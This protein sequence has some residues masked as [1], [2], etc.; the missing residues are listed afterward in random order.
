VAAALNGRRP[1]D[2][3]VDTVGAGVGDQVGRCVGAIG[4]RAV[5]YGESMAAG[6]EDL[7]VSGDPRATQIRLVGEQARDVG[8][9]QQPPG[10]LLVAGRHT[11]GQALPGG[12]DTPDPTV[13]LNGVPIYHTYHGTPTTPGTLTTWVDRLDE[14]TP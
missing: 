5:P 7:L 1:K 8:Q 9:T 3:D 6:G 2:V 11:R 4:G 10:R 12:Q 13:L 14:A